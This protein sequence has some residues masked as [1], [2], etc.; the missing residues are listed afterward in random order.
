MGWRNIVDTIAF[1]IQDLG[2]SVT[3]IGERLEAWNAP[4]HRVLGF[5]V[6]TWSDHKAARHIV[7]D[8]SDV[9][10]LCGLQPGPF[11]WENINH[12]HDGF[13]WPAGVCPVCLQRFHAETGGDAWRRRP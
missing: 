9:Q 6:S 11:G 7:K 5:K 12:I 2:A 4:M 8:T 10:A 1:A 13:L 3:R